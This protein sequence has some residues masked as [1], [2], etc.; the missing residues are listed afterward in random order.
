MPGEP[1][2]GLFLDF[3]TD[4]VDASLCISE[5]PK[6]MGEDK[7]STIYIYSISAFLLLVVAFVVFRKLYKKDYSNNGKLMPLSIIAGTLIYFVWGGFPYIYGPVDWPAVHINSVLE[8]I[9]WICLWGGLMLMVTSIGWL[10]FLRTLGRKQDVLIQTGLYHL[11]RNPQ[12]VGCITYG[13]GFAV[14]WPSWYAMGW[15]LLIVATTHMMVLTE[16]E[17]LLNIH[18]EEYMQYCKRVPRYLGFPH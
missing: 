11:S 2:E 4:L 3:N 1:Y 16:E 14:L 8:T 15:V 10:G 13:I 12:V 7:M 18:G 6:M 9:G 5:I 17:H